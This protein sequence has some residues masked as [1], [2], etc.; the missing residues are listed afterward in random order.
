MSSYPTPIAMLPAAPAA[1]TPRQQLEALA[2]YKPQVMTHIGDIALHA[3]RVPS[4]AQVGH[5]SGGNML[6]QQYDLSVEAVIEQV[7]RRV[8]EGQS[9]SLALSRIEAEMEPATTEANTAVMPA[10]TSAADERGLTSLQ[11]CVQLNPDARPSAEADADFRR[12]IAAAMRDE[13]PA[14]RSSEFTDED[15]YKTALAL[16][17]PWMEAFGAQQQA[18]HELPQRA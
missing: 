2:D 8:R 17:P 18:K 14:L 3:L 7:L 6:S 13:Y 1:K 4:M 16:L 15:V 12:G 9:L 5:L 11:K 10:T